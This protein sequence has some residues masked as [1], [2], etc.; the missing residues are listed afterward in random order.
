[1]LPERR[2]KKNT[3]NHFVINRQKHAKG[4]S[5]RPVS[6]GL[7]NIL[8]AKCVQGA[9]IRQ[10]D[11]AQHLELPLPK[12]WCEEDILQG[13]SGDA[14]GWTHTGGPPVPWPLG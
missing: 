10:L 5:R 13:L 1:M 7:Q 2:R 6:T 4:R 9:M 8:A 11:L 12:V 14:W 3:Q